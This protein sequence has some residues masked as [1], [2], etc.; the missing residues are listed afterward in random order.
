MSIFTIIVK[1]CGFDIAFST[2]LC[3][4]HYKM[5]NHK[6]IQWYETFSDI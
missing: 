3:N 6:Y 2:F 4:M 1:L 5:A